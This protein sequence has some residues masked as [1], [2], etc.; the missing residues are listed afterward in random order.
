MGAPG[1]LIPAEAPGGHLQNFGLDARTITT[2]AMVGRSSFTAPD[3]G[4][5]VESSSISTSEDET[6]N[7]RS[8]SSEFSPIAIESNRKGSRLAGKIQSD[9]LERDIGDIYLPSSGVC[10]VSLYAGKKATGRESHVEDIHRYAID[11][12]RKPEFSRELPT[13]LLEKPASGHEISHDLRDGNFLERNRIVRRGS[14]V[15]QCQVI[16][17]PKNE[18]SRVNNILHN[19]NSERS[20][21]GLGG[22][23]ESAG[24]KSSFDTQGQQNVTIKDRM[25]EVIPNDDAADGSELDNFSGSKEAM[26]MACTD[27]SN[28]IKIHNMQID[29]VL[30]GVAEIL[31]EDLQIGER[32]GI[33]KSPIIRFFI[34]H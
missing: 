11:A 28:A 30:N 25:D 23:P 8:S 34:L 5:R 18:R 22:Q 6:A 19:S 16:N 12:A 33:G 29:P 3:Q 13:M 21:E 14:G 31:W 27:Q 7:T 2:V 20:A 32:I 15:F 4:A 10:A 17:L 1:T 24:Y 9:L 26:E